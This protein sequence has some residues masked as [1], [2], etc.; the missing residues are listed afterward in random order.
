MNGTQCGGTTN[1]CLKRCLGG[2]CDNSPVQCPPDNNLDDCSVPVC[3]S[4]TGTCPYR[5]TS[6]TGCSDGN[7]CTT[8]DVCVNGTCRGSPVICSPSTNPCR[9]T[10]CA[11]GQCVDIKLSGLTC[12]ADK[13]KCTVGD[14]CVN[15]DCTPGTRTFCNSTDQCKVALCNAT[16]GMCVTQ[17]IPNDRNVVCND[18]Q[19]C[20]TNDRC[21]NG[22]C[23]GDINSTLAATY[24]QCGATPPPPTD[25]KSVTDKSYIIFSVAGAGALIGAIV[26]M[27]FLIKKIRDSKLMD[28]DSWNPD[29]FS[30]IGAN[31]LYKGSEKNR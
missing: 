17:N 23:T 14:V 30:S 22:T 8:N 10:T 31:P 4:N 9:N 26:G 21:V 11:F 20:T 16:T 3:D 5:P 2:V 27:A 24:E 12:D 15:G 18:Q 7:L 19:F 28:P 1:L 25:T 13:D 29:S 6:G